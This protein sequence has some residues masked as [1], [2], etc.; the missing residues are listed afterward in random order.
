M[1]D[2]FVHA[3]EPGSPAPRIAF[4]AL[5][6][7]LVL[8]LLVTA[9]LGYRSFTKGSPA[10][11]PTPRNASKPSIVVILTDD[12]RWDTLWAMPAVQRDLV[13][14]GITFKNAFVVNSACCPSRA[15]I[16]T[17]QYSHST[18]VYT[19]RGSEGGFRSFNDGST[20]ATWLDT[21]YTSALIGKYLNNYE[22]AGSNGQVPLGWDHW[23]AFPKAHYDNFALNIDGTV[24][25]FGSATADYSTD[26]LADQ[27]AKFIQGTEGPL[28]LYFA[29]KAPHYPAQPMGADKTTFSHLGKWRPRS[30][31][32][33]DMSD[34]PQWAR[35]QAPLTAGAQRRID[36]FRLA[37]MQTLLPVDRAVGRI[38][39]A[40][41]QTGRLGDTMIV[42][43]SDNGMLW[44]EHRMTGKGNAY[45]ESIRVPMVV[46][47]DPLVTQPGSSEDLVLNIDIAPTAA[48]LAG[49]RAPGA[50]GRSLVPLIE[51]NPDTPWRTDFLVEHF[52]PGGPRGHPPTYC[53]IRT[54]RYKY[55]DYMWGEDE[56]YDLSKDRFEMINL[57]YDPSMSHELDQLK[58]DEKQLCVPPPPR[59]LDYYARN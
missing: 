14:Q 35:D 46:R 39:D 10:E 3:P 4:V 22:F 8:A 55:V 56:L 50:E 19:N 29:P 43:M 31:N 28:L 32:E 57:I 18:N 24:Q 51:N 13:D 42:F 7:T 36:R 33:A 49:V 23:V 12:Q 53:A 9:T 41:D 26:V 21:D 30:Y 37:Q 48:E 1:D 5:V 6:G 58:Q 15:S 47:Y 16:L 25:Q 27:A 52:S 11:S 59:K 45:E 2:D 38:V 44:G 34:K 17:G 54:D 20:M 40:L